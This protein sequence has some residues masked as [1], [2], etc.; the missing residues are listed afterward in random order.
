MILMAM[1]IYVVSYLKIQ[2]VIVSSCLK[3]PTL[4][5][6]LAIRS[7]NR[8]EFGFRCGHTEFALAISMGSFTAAK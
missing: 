4:G 6:Y 2:A 5:L 8:I 7:N 3:A 1:K